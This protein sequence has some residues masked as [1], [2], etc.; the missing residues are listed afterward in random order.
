MKKIF[1]L[2]FNLNTY[3]PEERKL[4]FSQLSTDK[5]EDLFKAPDRCVSN[6]MDFAR[7]YNV[8]ESTSTGKIEMIL[9]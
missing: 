1:T 5:K 2:K 9:N 6:I 7:A 8:K 4:V 3:R